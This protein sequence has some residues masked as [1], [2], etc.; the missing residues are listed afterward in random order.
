MTSRRTAGRTLIA[1][2]WGILTDDG[3]LLDE[4]GIPRLYT[5]KADAKYDCTLDDMKPVRVT[6][7]YPRL[8]PRR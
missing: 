2:T 4:H 7:R 1:G 5:S 8:R 3:P 6:V